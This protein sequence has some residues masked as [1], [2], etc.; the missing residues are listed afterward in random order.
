MMNGLST[1]ENKK[2]FAMYLQ[3]KTDDA[4]AKPDTKISRHPISKQWK[5]RFSELRLPGIEPEA[6]RW[7]RWIL[8]LNHK[9]L[10][11]LVWKIYTYNH[12]SKVGFYLERKCLKQWILVRTDFV[13]LQSSNLEGETIVRKSL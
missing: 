1:M 3:V 12:D 13:V 7:Q 2:D 9:R 6:Q 11:S 8:P 4:I 5:K 10:L